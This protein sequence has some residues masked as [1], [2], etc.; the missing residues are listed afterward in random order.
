M[1]ILRTRVRRAEG[2][3]GGGNSAISYSSCDEL[4]FSRICVVLLVLIGDAL[5]PEQLVQKHCDGQSDCRHNDSK[6]E[7]KLELLTQTLASPPPDCDS[8]DDTVILLNIRIYNTMP[9]VHPYAASLGR[10]QL[11]AR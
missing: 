2:A 5:L 9:S 4:H 7:T 1:G 6:H 10:A 11:E 3:G 8:S